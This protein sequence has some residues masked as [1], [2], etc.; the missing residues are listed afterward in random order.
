MHTHLLVSQELTEVTGSQILYCTF[1]IDILN[2]RL[3]CRVIIKPAKNR[4]KQQV[5]NIVL[6]FCNGV[7]I[8]NRW[9]TCRVIIRP[10]KNRQELGVT[11]CPAVLQLKSYLLID[12][13]YRPSAESGKEGEHIDTLPL[14]V[15]ISQITL[16]QT[17]I[18]P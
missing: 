14:C 16:S 18:S 17:H 8:L 6:Q 5:S 3:T 13:C 12:Q 4:L 7:L 10:V 2:R 1:V 9:L 11:S 15:Y